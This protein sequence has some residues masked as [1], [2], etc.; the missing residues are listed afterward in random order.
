MTEYTPY[1]VTTG[2]R[3]FV[4]LIMSLAI[5]T[6]DNLAA[7]ILLLPFAVV[8]A[9]IAL[10]TYVVVDSAFVLATSFMLPHTGPMKLVL[11]IQSVCGIIIGLLCFFVNS[12]GIA[13]SG[14]LYLA[15]AQASCAAVG[16]YLVARDIAEYH[17][18][19][20]CYAS[21]CIA[22]V[23]AIVLLSC[24]QAKDHRSLLLPYSYLGLFGL[25]QFALASHMLFR[26]SF[27]VHD[28]RAWR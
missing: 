25:N 11:R 2:I 7:T 13:L 14:F 28:K 18:S 9:L 10:S 22:C 4:A 8:L 12:G 27:E 26:E 20:W 17:N 6:V 3:G 16:K 5:I 24:H 21:A 15:A 19:R 1:W 23:S